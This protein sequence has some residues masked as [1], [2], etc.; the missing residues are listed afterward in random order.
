MRGYSDVGMAAA[1]SVAAAPCVL[2]G[3]A[4]AVSGPGRGS[5][6][7]LHLGKLR[8]LRCAG[9]S[10][11]A[12]SVVG[13]ARWMGAAGAFGLKRASAAWRA[14]LACW[15]SP[16]ASPIG[17]PADALQERSSGTFILSGVRWQ[18]MG[19]Y[20]GNM[21]GDSPL[22]K[23]VDVIWRPSGT[24][25]AAAQEAGAISDG[26]RDGGSR[27]RRQT[28]TCRRWQRAAPNRGRRPSRDSPADRRG[29]PARHRPGAAG[30][31][32]PG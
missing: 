31:A 14:L 11:P 28:R 5:G 9:C 6:C 2:L 23:S 25:D 29:S 20:I 19:K 24:V 4:A 7:A 32:L 13:D 21:G 8:G 1:R 15:L 26:I 27:V 10:P 18:T 12:A 22:S 16:G 17:L 30:P 3:A